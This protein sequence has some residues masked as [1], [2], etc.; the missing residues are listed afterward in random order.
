MT[1]IYGDSNVVKFLPLLK[2]K[3]SDPAI[4]AATVSRATNVVLLQDLLSSPKVV[5]SLIIISAITNIITA[6]FFE[7]FDAMLEHCRTSFN[8]LLIWIQEGRE[9]LDGFAE[10]VIILLQP[11]YPKLVCLL[12]V[13]EPACLA[14]ILF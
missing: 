2:E 5:H 13:L 10:T 6:K 3:K 11:A 12:R 1:A 7:D 14:C 9:N 4:Q 8:D